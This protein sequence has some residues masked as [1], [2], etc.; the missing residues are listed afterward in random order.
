M[1]KILEVQAK[2]KFFKT[3]ANRRARVEDRIPANL[4]CLVHVNGLRPIRFIISNISKHGLLL[5]NERAVYLHV[6][7]GD[8]LT[9]RTEIDGQK[10]VLEGVVVRSEAENMGSVALRDMNWYKDEAGEWGEPPHVAPQAA[11][12]AK[13]HAEA[14]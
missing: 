2:Q 8:K 9:I 7:E 6:S 12:Q 4:D 1:R 11:P 3:E 13:P 14:V 10:F 5:R